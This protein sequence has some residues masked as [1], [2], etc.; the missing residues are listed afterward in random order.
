MF[1]VIWLQPWVLSTISPLLNSQSVVHCDIDWICTD[2]I[3]III[4]V[5]CLHTC[6]CLSLSNKTQSTSAFHDEMM[7]AIRIEYLFVCEMVI[8]RCFLVT[9]CSPSIKMIFASLRQK[10]RDKRC[11]ARQREWESV[12]WGENHY[13]S[14]NWEYNSVDREL[15]FS[16]VKPTWTWNRRDRR[17][18][19]HRPHRCPELGWGCLWSRSGCSTLDSVYLE[20]LHFSRSRW[21]SIGHQETID[22]ERSRTERQWWWC[23]HCSWVKFFSQAERMRQHGHRNRWS[24]VTLYPEI[25][26]DWGSRW[27]SW[28]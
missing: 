2:D 18:L 11:T 7:T 23:T 1:E 21:R 16:R 25:R 17:Q 20:V 24:R 5:K 4:I 3:I 8:S 28:G 9:R 27:W 14:R 19:S 22:I 12:E 10:A 26:W 6:E 13:M 15:T